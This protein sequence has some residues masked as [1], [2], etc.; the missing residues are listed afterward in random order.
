M[1]QNLKKNYAKFKQENETELELY[2]F[3]IQ[4]NTKIHFEFLRSIFEINLFIHF[5]PPVLVPGRSLRHIFDKVTQW[6]FYI[7]SK[8]VIWT[9]KNEI[10]CTG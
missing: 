6:H 7:T 10:S 5:Y 8:E 1:T 9:Q 2:F 4:N 3:S